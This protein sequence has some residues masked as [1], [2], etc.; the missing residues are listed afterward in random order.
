MEHHPQPRSRGL[1]RPLHLEDRLRSVLRGHAAVTLGVGPQVAVAV[2][3][4]VAHPLDGLA[5]RDHLVPVAELAHG[6]E[7]R[8]QAVGKPLRDA[9]L[10]RGIHVGGVEAGILLDILLD[11]LADGLLRHARGEVERIDLLDVVGRDG[12]RDLRQHRDLAEEL[13]HVDPD[14]SPPAERLG[15]P[16]AIFGL[17]ERGVVLADLVDVADHLVGVVDGRHRVVPEVRCEFVVAVDVVRL[18]GHDLR[19]A[20]VAA[21]GVVGA[22]FAQ[23]DQLV[24]VGLQIALHV[25]VHG[26]QL[27]LEQFAG[28]DDRFA[29]ALIL[30]VELRV[31]GLGVLL[32]AARYRRRSQREQG[33]REIY[34]FHG[35]C[36]LFRR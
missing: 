10:V 31:P 15:E 4:A 13:H 14:V 25:V 7:L 23:G 19:L 29:G 32:K 16:L 27:T 17:G 11:L 36:S 21:I 24:P 6:V 26:R 22:D 18:D 12:G 35:H 33:R 1:A 5:G 20:H 3:E 8:Q 9:E 34:L 30:G 28:V 2:A